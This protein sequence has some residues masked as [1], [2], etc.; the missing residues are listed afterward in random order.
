VKLFQIEEPDGS[1]VDPDA[2]GVAIG[3][4]ISG[5]A[6]EVAVAVGGNAAVLAD[7]EGFALDLTV[8][9]PQAAAERWQ[10]L[11]EGARLRAERMLAQPVTHAVLAVATVPDAAFAA[12]LSTAGAAAGLA[13]LRIVA[14]SRIGARDDPRDDQ[15]AAPA[16]LDAA[17]LAEDLAPRPGAS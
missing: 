1:P 11:F 16:V 4:D 12:R 6:A 14:R 15:G 9:P 7:R 13:V 5:L 8:P 10:E 2:P 17:I 3:I